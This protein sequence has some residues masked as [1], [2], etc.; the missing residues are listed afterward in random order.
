M[1]TICCAE[2]KFDGTTTGG[3]PFSRGHIYQILANPLYIGEIRHKDN[4]YPGE[5]DAII[6]R[7]FWDSVQSQLATNRKD[8]RNGTRMK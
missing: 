8:R 3:T 1:S 7:E 2:A 4:V 5:H 6:D